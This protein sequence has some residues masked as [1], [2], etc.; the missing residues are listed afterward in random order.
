MGVLFIA[1]TLAALTSAA[2]GVRERIHRSQSPD[3]LPS[4]WFLAAGTLAL[5]AVARVGD[6][7][8]TIAELG[9]ESAR[10]RGWYEGRRSAQVVAIAAIGSCWL[11]VVLV[12]IWRVPARR[13][14]YLP[15]S[16]ALLTLGCYSFIRVISLH[17]IDAVVYRRHL[18]GI[19]VGVVIELCIVF[20]IAVLAAIRLRVPPPRPRL[21]P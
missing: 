15:M 14:R 11:V 21:D 13:R 18:W 12:A 10:D 5:M 20:T 8:S 2:V 7:G 9:R 4:F 19:R 1:Y 17:H 16:L 3:L 6:I